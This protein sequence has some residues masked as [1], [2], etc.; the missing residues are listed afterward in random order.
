M[1]AM[2]TFGGAKGLRFLERF[3]VDGQNPAMVRAR[4]LTAY[5]QF[6]AGMKRFAD[7]TAAAGSKVYLY[8]FNYVSPE[9]QKNGLGAAHAAEL[10]FVFNYFTGN[11][12]SAP[13]AEQ[14]AAEIH[15]RWAN[16]IKSG[17]PNTGPAPPGAA[18]WPQYDPENRQVLFLQPKLSSGPLPDRENI[19]YVA[20]IMFDSGR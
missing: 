20:D 2:R 15:T 8:Q 14:L 9:N 11:S 5:G 7:L 4:Q 12:R 13:G 1:L 10:P 18:A 17:D 3:R 16:F 19:D 6:I